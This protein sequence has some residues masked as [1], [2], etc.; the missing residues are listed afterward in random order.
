MTFLAEINIPCI[1]I[2]RFHSTATKREQNALST[3]RLDALA[4]FRATTFKNPYVAEP[5][6]PMEPPPMKAYQTPL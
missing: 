1:P 4:F 3:F 5:N 6:K 2:D